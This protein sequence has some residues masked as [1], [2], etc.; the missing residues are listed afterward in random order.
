MTAWILTIAADY[1]Q[2]LE[3]AFAD[4][5]WDFN[6]RRDIQPGD[7]LFFW[8]AGRKE[9]VGWATAT[10]AIRPR[11]PAMPS[12]R[13]LDDSPTRYKFRVD[14]VKRSGEPQSSPDWSEI[15][16]Q[17]G[18]GASPN[19]PVIEVKNA[20]GEVFLKGLFVANPSAIE[21]KVKAQLAERGKFLDAT[22][23]RLRRLTDVVYRPSQSKFRDSLYVAYDGRCAMSGS[24]VAEALEAAH[25]VAYKGMESDAVQNGILLRVDLHRLFDRFLLTVGADLR[26]HM[27]PKLRGGAYA[28]FHGTP[29]RMP[30]NPEHAPDIEALATHWKACDYMTAEGFPRIVS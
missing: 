25:I 6:Q 8:Q 16:T 10:T 17:V 12:A 28:P 21:A 26:V 9:L 1:P 20:D 18:T 15:R 4:G 23:R 5:F 29:I 27:D 14:L 19:I 24:D 7:D 13:W 30:E 11:T 3:Y 22:D 2:H